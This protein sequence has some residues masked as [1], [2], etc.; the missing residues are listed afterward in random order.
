MRFP[1]RVEN[2]EEVKSAKKKVLSHFLASL[3]Q[4]TKFCFMKKAPHSKAKEPKDSATQNPAFKGIKWLIRVG[5]KLNDNM[6]PEFETSS[7]DILEKLRLYTAN[8]SI[9]DLKLARISITDSLSEVDILER[10]IFT[11]KSMAPSLVRILLSTEAFQ[12]VV[13]D[14][15]GN[16]FSMTEY[17]DD[18]LRLKRITQDIMRDL[19]FLPKIYDSE[20]LTNMIF[21]SIKHSHQYVKDQIFMC[22]YQIIESNDKVVDYLLDLLVKNVDL[23]CD[24]LQSLEGFA[25]KPAEKERVRQHVLRQILPSAK[26]KDLASVIKFLTSTTDESNAESTVESFRAHLVVVNNNHVEDVK[27][28]IDATFYIIHQIKTSLQFNNNFS[29]AYMAALELSEEELTVLDVWVLYCTH[30]IQ[31]LKQKTQAL[32]C[33]IAGKVL[34]EETIINS[35]EG[36]GKEIE[37]LIYSI[38]DVMT[39]MMSNSS[40]TIISLGSG[41]ISALFNEFND[42]GLFQDIIATLITQIGI[43]QEMNKDR[44]IKV[45]ERLSLEHPEKLRVHNE[46][47]QSLIW[48]HETIHMSLFERI[49]RII[50]ELTFH[51]LSDIKE[52]SGS[53]LL[54]GFRKMLSSSRNETQQYGVIAAAALV[55]RFNDI[56]EN[57]IEPYS[58]YFNQVINI[59]DNDPLCGNLFFKQIVDKSERK[60]IINDFLIEKLTSGIQQLLT[61]HSSAD[62]YSLD[63]T[64][65]TINFPIFLH[66]EHSKS[67][68]SMHAYKESVSGRHVSIVFTTYGLKLLLDCHKKLGHDLKE[69]LGYLF[70]APMIIIP[71]SE[72]NMVNSIS[73]THLAH[74]WVTTLLNYFAENPDQSCIQRLNNLVDIERILITQMEHVQSFEHP[75]F[76]LMFKQHKTL[77]KK[78]HESFL[79][80]FYFYEQYRLYFVQPE[81]NIFNMFSLLD[82]KKE[83]DI[84]MLLHLVIDY[85]YIICSPSNAL[86]VA[87][88]YDSIDIVKF[89]SNNILTSLIND[90]RLIAIMIVE[91]ILNI[92]RIH[93]Q[94]PKNKDKG[95]FG[96]LCMAICKSD[97]RL[98]C[99]KYLVKLMKDSQ[100][101]DL[102]K[103]LIILLRAIL[104]CGPPCKVD[105]LSKEY[106]VLCEMCRETLTSNHPVLPKADVK[107]ILQIFFDHHDKPIDEVSLFVTTVFTYDILGGANNENW[108]SLTPETYPLYYSQCFITLYHHLALFKKQ[109]TRNNRV[110]TDEAIVM[111]MNRLNRVNAVMKG[112]LLHTCNI[113]IPSSVLKVILR[114]GTNW[115][116]ASIALF[117][118]LGDAKDADY[119]AVQQYISISRLIKRQMQIIVDHVRRNEKSLL[120]CLPSISRALS[121]W[122]YSLKNV[123]GKCDNGEGLMI[124]TFRER[125]LVGEII[126]ETQIPTYVE[127]Q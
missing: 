40:D 26:M 68:Q 119:N 96:E 112:L 77:L 29:R 124:S 62:R 16:Y 82:I 18:L 37:I 36:H 86:F 69:E 27:G 115:I 6:A 21:D 118:F 41:I 103:P 109:I 11:P 24:I 70:N 95:K 47:I 97:Q 13:I 53:Q 33:K 126:Q 123:F 9:Q 110:L 23:T 122:T 87:Q 91:R 55:N 31:P 74:C 34:T 39:W 63:D 1:F 58:T 73:I 114:Y 127:S 20:H 98:G 106:S 105:I 25:L 51:K 65:S 116:D 83:D 67:T 108:P 22:L 79:E 19:S 45:L 99:F 111:M 17:E 76:G 85:E 54:I 46:M 84:R 64:D 52:Q 61:E 15:L 102:K 72:E 66:N 50:V 38:T 100:I 71:E 7:I 92:F 42:S 120:S 4:K 93:F 32:I 107:T 81:P 125:N 101:F 88:Q 12:N 28:K 3:L 35:I 113:S 75:V 49:A 80:Q 56:I 78:H 90:D 121:S 8:C 10:W 94:M 48:N 104:H 89:L 14:A 2:L 43:G 57:D 5:I 59:I 44:A 60:E 30:S 117:A